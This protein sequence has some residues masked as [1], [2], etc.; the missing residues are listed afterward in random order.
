L[1]FVLSFIEKR[2]ICGVVCF[3]WAVIKYP[4]QKQPREGKIYVAD[5]SRS[6]SSLRKVKVRTQDLGPETMEKCFFL[7]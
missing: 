2:N 3:L 4:D 6:S 5:T 7:D 1:F